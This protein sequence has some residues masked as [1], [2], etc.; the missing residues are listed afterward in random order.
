MVGIHFCGGHI[1][2]IA[3]FTQANR[4]AMEKQLPPCHRHETA[5]CCKDENIVHDAQNFKADVSQIHLP[6]IFPI[7][8]FEPS[9]VLAEII[10]SSVT[11][12]Q[13][14]FNYDP[15]LPKQN[16]TIALQVFLI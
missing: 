3:L 12:Q 10:P 14:F 5:P 1:Q 13:S 16:L 6:G 15:P 8:I 2:D 11:G 7:A 9:V 4:C